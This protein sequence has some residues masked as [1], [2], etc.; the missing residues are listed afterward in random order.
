MDNDT[1]LMCL[2]RD[3]QFCWWWQWRMTPYE[4]SFIVFTCVFVGL[5]SVVEWARLLSLVQL[6]LAYSRI[7]R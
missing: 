4:R 1:V 5:R 3:W 7:D 6:F 2:V